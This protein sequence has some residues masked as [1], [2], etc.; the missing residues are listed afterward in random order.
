MI[1]FSNK[2]N[3]ILI[4]AALIAALFMT[5][6]YSYLLFHS[7]VEML[8]IVIMGSIFVLAWNTRH[9]MNNHFFLF[10]GIS[11]LFV[12]GIDML[13][14]L[15]YKGMGIFQGY[16]ANLPT[17][18]WIVA[19]YTQSISLLLAPIWLRRRLR[20]GSTLASYSIVTGLLLWSIFSGGF[21]ACYVDGV[22]LTPF[23]IV[24]E[25][26]IIAI[27][28]LAV[29][30]LWI[31][32]KSFEPDVWRSLLAFIGLTVLAELAFTDYLGVYDNANLI[33]HILRMVS[34][35]FLYSALLRTGLQRPFE[36]V[37]RDLKQK[38]DDLVKSEANLQMLFEVSP[39]PLAITG[40]ADGRLIKVNQA[41]LDLMELSE[42]DASQFTALDFY[43]HPSDRQE[44]L[45]ELQQTGKTGKRDQELKTKSGK[46]I[47]CLVDLTLISYRGEECVM[48]GLADIT[49]QK[50]TQQELL[51]LST[52][53]ALTGIHNRT[54]FESE[55]E[56]LK[57]SRLF[58][59]S[60]IMLDIDDLKVINDNRGHAA[61]DKALQ[62][63]ASQIE[64][65][66]RAE[67][68]F[69]RIGGDE[70]AILLP[71]AD[72]DSASLV[73]QRIRKQLDWHGSQDESQRVRVSIGYGTA[74]DKTQT[75]DALKQ[76]DAG[77]YADKSSK[78][79]GRLT[80]KKSA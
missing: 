67:E 16:G 68:V 57:K 29:I 39:F 51:H 15:A 42:Q 70:F 7:I 31:K 26:L 21:P 17:Q 32:R 37:F 35:L 64:E 14:T 75:G 66:L 4:G 30:P 63:A 18:L 22:G 78:K 24:S 23:K 10:I 50:R 72:V 61:G 8:T 53:D 40:K 13:H 65:I 77:M 33:G 38:E 11:F 45:Q 62:T 46:H 19:R 58:P 48:V 27:L 80:H 34:Y 20:T 54:Y 5:S 60:I 69:A 12:S 6:R 47:W 56:R 28:L 79:T 36:L 49:E 74:E 41:C 71:Q 3:R 59:L 73:V 25:Y 1:E 76:A 55:L 2:T 9:W 52:H 43:L 44:L